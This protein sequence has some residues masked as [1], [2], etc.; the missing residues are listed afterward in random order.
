MEEKLFQEFPPVPT[1]EW[2]FYSSNHKAL[3]QSYF[4]CTIENNEYICANY[5]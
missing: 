3:Y 4:Y 5:I 1:Q 2:V